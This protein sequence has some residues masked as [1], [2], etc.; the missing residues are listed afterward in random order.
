MHYVRFSIMRP[1][2]GQEERVRVLLDRLNA[3]YERQ[4]GY[5]GGYRLV[6]A[7][8]SERVGRFGVWERQQDAEHAA[9]HDQALAI[10]SEVQLAVD[11][12]SHLEYSFAGIPSA[13][14]A[15]P[16]IESRQPASDAVAGANPLLAPDLAPTPDAGQSEAGQR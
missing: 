5:L 3:F 16:P 12:S 6:H 14:F 4:P 7:D 1:L 2:R 15:K 9:Q 11:A 8:G 10:R 13:L